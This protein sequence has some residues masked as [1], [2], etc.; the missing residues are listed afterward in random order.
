MRL[1]RF[2]KRF[3]FGA[4]ALRECERRRSLSR[5]ETVRRL[6]PRSLPTESSIR[7]LLCSGPVQRIALD[8]G[9]SLGRVAP[10]LI[11]GVEADRRI[12]A[13]LSNPFG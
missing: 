3:L 9:K 12:E 6:W 8:C 13:R 7:C 10:N 1:R 4:L 5:G 2:Q 11:P